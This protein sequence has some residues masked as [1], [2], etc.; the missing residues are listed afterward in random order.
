MQAKPNKREVSV[1]ATSVGLG[2]ATGKSHVSKYS[3]L[4]RIPYIVIITAVLAG[5]M[6]CYRNVGSFSLM[7]K[8]TVLDI[9]DD[10]LTALRTVIVLILCLGA[11][12][13]SISRLRNVG[14]NWRVVLSL[15]VPVWNVWTAWLLILSP[16]G[17]RTEKKLGTWNRALTVVYS[18]GVVM[19]FTWVWNNYERVE[20]SSTLGQFEK[21]KQTVDFE[22]LIDSE[23]LKFLKC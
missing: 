1:A 3:G 16:A 22:Q 19:A 11:V 23:K 14:F 6:S 18:I 8:L 10:K 2:N 21:L 12:G 5:I 20:W 15:L 13:A 17:Y 4:R 9:A 7:E